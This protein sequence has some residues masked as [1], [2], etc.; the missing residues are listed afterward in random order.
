MQELICLSVVDVVNVQKDV[1]LEGW[2]DCNAL[3]ANTQKF[4]ESPVFKQKANESAA[5][6]DGLVPYLGGRPATLQNMVRGFVCQAKPTI[7]HAISVQWNV[8]D[9]INT[10]STYNASFASTLPAGYLAQARDLA[11]WH[12]SQIFS[13]SELFAIENGKTFRTFAANVLRLADCGGH[14][15]RRADSHP[16]N[17]GS[18]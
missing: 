5:F 7:A 13:S 12:E 8:Y 3:T 9:F 14:L 16:D 4:Y 10:Q 17:T 2:L 15:S 1:S 11:N 18:L 6:L